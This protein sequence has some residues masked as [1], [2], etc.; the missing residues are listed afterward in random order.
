MSGRLAHIESTWPLADV[1][2]S[3]RRCEFRRAAA[4]SIMS[5]AER[6]R[7][8]TAIGKPPMISTGNSGSMAVASTR[9]RPALATIVPIP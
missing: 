4:T 5:C 9:D 6:A 1:N 8:I 2:T 3:G 7:S